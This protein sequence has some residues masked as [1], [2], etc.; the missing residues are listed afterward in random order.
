MIEKGSVVLNCPLADVNAIFEMYAPVVKKIFSKV[1]QY[2]VDGL[3]ALQSAATLS[4]LSLK[5]LLHFQYHDRRVFNTKDVELYSLFKRYNPETTFLVLGNDG[6]HAHTQVA[7]S[8]TMHTFYKKCGAAYDPLFVQQELEGESLL[9]QPSL[10]DTE[11]II[12]EFYAHC[13]L[14]KSESIV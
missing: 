14:K 2:K 4:D 9:L 3:Q 7:L 8:K 12:Q 11:R 10:E 1:T 13:A 5:V 6:G